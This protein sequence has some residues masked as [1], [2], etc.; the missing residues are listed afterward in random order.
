[1]TTAEKQIEAIT[2]VGKIRNKLFKVV[3]HQL[4][5]P[6]PIELGIPVDTLV[7]PIP[8]RAIYSSRGD[9]FGI[10]GGVY[11]SIQPEHFLREV[12]DSVIG[13]KNVPL[14]KLTYHEFRGG[15]KIAFRIPIKEIQFKGSA[16]LNEEIKTWLE[17]STGF[18]GYAK[19]ELGV[20]T[21]RLVC[22]NGM[23]A[24]FMDFGMKLRHTKRN[25]AKALAY[26]SEVS[27]I[28][29]LIDDYGQFLES[30]DKIKIGKKEIHA[31]ACKMMKIKETE[32]R[33]TM[34]AQRKA[35]Y[36]K[37]MMGMEVELS[38]CGNTAF[39]LLQGATYYTNHIAKAD[40]SPEAI[41]TFINT[42]GG[43]EINDRAQDFVSLL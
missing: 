32:K 5:A 29:N 33:E 26:T 7:Q 38:R 20:F 22:T 3:D 17:F 37:I 8:N 35:V 30:I 31:M 15:Q 42:G 24:K 2:R 28:L 10:V 1:M 43:R 34:R 21:E 27:K 4:E 13:H 36:D 41:E 25:N 19:T 14:S 23:T 18:G 11:E 9:F 40:E 6:T 12:E 39:G 16:N